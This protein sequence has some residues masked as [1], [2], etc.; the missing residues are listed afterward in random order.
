M[1]S[2]GLGATAR[3]ADRDLDAVVALF[4]YVAQVQSRRPKLFAASDRADSRKGVIAL[5]D[6][7][8]AQ[9]LPGSALSEQGV[10]GDA[11]RLLTAH[12]SKGLEWDVVVVAAVQEGVW[13]DLRRRSTLLESERLGRDAAART[14]RPQDDADRR[15]AAVLR[16]RHPRAS[17]TGHHGRR[18]CRGRRRPAVPL[19]EQPRRRCRA[20][21]RAGRPSALPAR[22]GG[23]AA[24]P[25]RRPHNLRAGTAG[26]RDATRKAGRCGRPGGASRWHLR[27]ILRVG[28]DCS[29]RPA[30]TT[31]WCRPSSR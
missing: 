20:A 28:G 23:D 25:H 21:L 31:R 2:R 6:E 24:A 19:P 3:S 13:P 10:R 29:S 18:Q 1:A 22:H 14:G 27:P 9:H 12:R 11:V 5:L 8:E 26:C 4:D 15:A 17:A 16:R 7:L 30:A